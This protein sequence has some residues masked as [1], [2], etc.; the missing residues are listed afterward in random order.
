MIN[1]KPTVDIV[2]A[3]YNAEQNIKRLLSSL[4]QQRE[5]GFMISNIVVHSDSSSDHTVELAS[6]IQDTRLRIINS[7]K[8]LGL[9]NVVK[10]AIKKTKANYLNIL[11]D[12]I[13]IANDE[14]IINIIKLF[15]KDKEIGLVSSNIIPFKGKTFTERSVVSGYN[16]FKRTALELE[17]GNNYLTS[18]GKSLTLSRKLIQKIILNIDQKTMGN[19]DLFLYLECIRVGM[20]FRL[21]KNSTIYFKCPSN[22]KDFV[23]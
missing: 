16:A 22:A 20:K 13:V 11:N 9:A 17:N 15:L 8:R 7:K 3:A 4:V 1:S 19:V 10:K 6:S 2:I 12:D 21:A 5:D 14:F 18:D 23:R